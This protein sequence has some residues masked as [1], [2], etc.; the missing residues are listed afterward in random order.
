MPVVVLILLWPRLRTLR[1]APAVLDWL[2]L[3]FVVLTYEMLHAVVPRCWSAT[4][5]PWLRQADRALLGA[6]A[7]SLLEPWVDAG[8]TTALSTAYASYYVL[9]VGLAIWCWRRNRVAFRCLIVGEVGALF[10]G[11]LGYLF[12]PAIGP[13]LFFEPGTFAAALDGDFIGELIRS[14]NGAHDGR[15]PRDAFPSLHTANAVTAVIVAWRHERRAL[16]VVAPLA[17]GIIAATVYL[18]FHYVI[19]V[20]AGAALAVAWQAWVPRLVA[21]ETHATSTVP[22]PERSTT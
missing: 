1:L 7:A 16:A 17:A 13:H 12:L 21:S 9:P 19:D 2:P 20:A 10:I 11:Y 3:P 6:D 4:I 22:S 14:L 5:D 15:Y 8:L 18:R